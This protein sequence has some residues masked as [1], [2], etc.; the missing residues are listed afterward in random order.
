MEREVCAVLIHSYS[1]FGVPITVPGVR[2]DVWWCAV[3]CVV[4]CA[5]GCAVRCAVRCGV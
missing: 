2:R 3:R 1:R 4:R 5:V